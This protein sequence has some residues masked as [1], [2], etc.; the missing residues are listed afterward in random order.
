MIVIKRKRA[1]EHSSGMLKK[2]A[3]NGAEKNSVRYMTTL[4]ARLK[5]RTAA[6]SEDV[7]S[8]RRTRAEVK[9]LS[10]R[11]LLRRVNTVKAP[12]SPKSLGER[13]RA[14]KMPTKRATS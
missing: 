3:M 12:I 14:V 10:T 13:I 8:L 5:Y 9:P 11:M 4:R 7:F 2:L 6:Y 1:R